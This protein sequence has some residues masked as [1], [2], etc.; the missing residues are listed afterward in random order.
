MNEITTNLICYFVLLQYEENAN[1]IVGKN[2]DGLT[3]I[4]PIKSC[5]QTSI[6]YNYYFTKKTFIFHRHVPQ[7]IAV[8]SHIH[9][10]HML[11]T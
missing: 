2:L 3:F 11:G 6:F 5:S 8:N 1:V 4:R 9:R 10:L 7:Q